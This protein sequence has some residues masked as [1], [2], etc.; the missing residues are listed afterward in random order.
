ML[1]VMAE[2]DRESART[3]KLVLQLT[4][5]SLQQHHPGLP[6]PSE[7]TLRREHTQLRSLFTLGKGG[8]SLSPATPYA[9]F[10]DL[11][12]GGHLELD[13]TTVN[14]LTCLP[15][16]TVIRRPDLLLA[17]CR[18]DSG[19]ASWRFA[20]TNQAFDVVALIADAAT[21]MAM[22]PGWPD[23]F[24]WRQARAGEVGW[25]DLSYAE[26]MIAARPVYAVHAVTIDGGL[27]YRADAVERFCAARNISMYLAA[28]RRP[29]AKARVERK[30]N[31]IASAFEAWF[32]AYVGR[33]VVERS[34]MVNGQLAVDLEVLE[35]AFARWVVQIHQRTPSRAN[36]LELS[37]SSIRGPDDPPIPASPSEVVRDA[38]ERNG[39][40]PNEMYA[41]QVF[42]AGLRPDPLSKDDYIRFLP[43]RWQRINRDGI[44]ID[45]RRYDGPMLNT[46]R[47]QRSQY[48]AKDGHWPVYVNRDDISRVWV[49]L[50]DGSLVET[51]YRH[52]DALTRPMGAE[53]FRIAHAMLRS[54]QRD[55]V[56]FD[57]VEA[58]ELALELRNVRTAESM[59][60]SNRARDRAEA[61][62]LL[63]Q[64]VNEHTDESPPNEDE[65]EQPGDDEPAYVLKMFEGSAD[66]WSDLL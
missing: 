4:I 59:K 61:G 24:R 14:I 20:P 66:A 43:Q 58:I 3:A 22:R 21:P 17:V 39:L 35:E 33:N 27:V 25:P 47:L 5:A 60:A 31:H 13:T 55:L 30:F 65:A 63:R 50:D 29:T 8:A 40:T 10:A 62:R 9:H 19:I 44:Q 45:Y 46:I 28:P 11:P 15:D 26:D 32:R 52:A 7:R 41:I 48:H 57:D 36:M 18:G 23:S 12:T 6:I 34:R 53:E 56:R 1:A 38:P 16:G 49:E 2:L 51:P 42:I 37:V 54:E 64:E